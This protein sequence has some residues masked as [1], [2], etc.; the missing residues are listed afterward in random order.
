[1]IGKLKSISLGDQLKKDSTKVL[2]RAVQGM[3]PRNKL[4]K[5]VMN[6]LKI[7][8]GEKHEHEA[9]KPEKIEL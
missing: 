5:P 8:T 2:K 7:Y 3:I 4:R 1:M 9:Q 6:K